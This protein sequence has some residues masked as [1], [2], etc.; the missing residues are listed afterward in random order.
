M[1]VYKRQ[2]SPNYQY[3]F[4][5]AGVR[6]RGSTGTNDKGLAEAFEATERTRIYKESHLGVKEGVT[7]DYA[8]YRF[9]TEHAQHL[10][11]ARKQLRHCELIGEYFKADTSFA[12][13]DTD[14]LARFV[15]WL[16]ARQIDRGKDD[17]EK[18]LVANATVN[19]VIA[20]FSKIYT[21]A[22]DTWEYPVKPIDFRKVKLREPSVRVRWEPVERID[23]LIAYA[24]P[25]IRPIIYT[26]LY[27]G[28]RLSSI[29]GLKWFD[30]RKDTIIFR[31][32]KSHTTGKAHEVP[33][34]PGLR[35]VLDGIERNS[36]YVFTY[37]G[38]PIGSIRKA[39]DT[40]TR[41]A[42]IDDFR[43]HD[44]RHTC[45]S[46]LVQSGTPLEIVKEI[47]GHAN[48]QTTLKY[49]HHKQDARRSALERTFNVSGL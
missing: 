49:A 34:V 33:I 1:S 7:V 36:E 14:G 32:V 13:I 10:K 9:L 16:R 24:A 25:H 22:R 21:L 40:A 18:R 12:T 6:Y 3:A 41:N 20:T 46:W 47:L 19:R 37:E 35:K 29:L 31:N 26:A 45:A 48:I 39:W 44:L 30:V 5:V 11:T 17:P 15:A 38:M 8:C 2:G 23:A 43:F 27:T 4:T 28:G 42:G